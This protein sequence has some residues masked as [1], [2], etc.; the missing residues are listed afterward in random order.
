M[1]LSYSYCYYYELP[2]FGA[3]LFLLQLI[4]INT[5]FIYVHR[6]SHCPHRLS[7]SSVLLSHFLSLISVSH[8]LKTHQLR[9]TLNSSKRRVPTTDILPSLHRQEGQAGSC[10]WECAENKETCAH[11]NR[12]HTD[13]TKKKQRTTSE[14]ASK[15]A[16]YLPT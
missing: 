2:Y 1:G 7:P 15:Q 3:Q 8:P 5:R 16:T 13:S 9:Y 11:A 14:E 12:H 4:T 10:R 6:N